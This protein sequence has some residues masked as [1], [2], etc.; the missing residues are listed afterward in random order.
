MSTTSPPALNRS[1]SAPPEEDREALTAEE[2]SIT[3]LKDAVAQTLETK[4]ILG[5]IRAQLRA[6]V[7]TA[8]DTQER[9]SG[10]HLENNKLNQLSQTE[11]GRATIA[12]VHDFLE[13]MDLHSTKSVFLAEINIDNE[14]DIKIDASD[15]AATNHLEDSNLPLLMQMMKR[16][17]ITSSSSANVSNTTSS[18]PRHNSKQ[19]YTSSPKT[20]GESKT[21]T[22]T[23]STTSQESKRRSSPRNNTTTTTNNFTNKNSTAQSS[24]R[25]T[26]SSKLQD[27]YDDDDYEDDNEF[28]D[29][30]KGRDSED[31]AFEIADDGLVSQSGS[32]ND[33]SS[34]FLGNSRS[35]MNQGDRSTDS[36]NMSTSIVQDSMDVSIQGSLAMDSYDFVEMAEQTSKT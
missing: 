33:D 11:D 18:S 12:L 15:Y 35:R 8:I 32:F 5:T 22:H 19:N 17:P 25:S 34:D 9:A 24:P 31:D 16:T 29:V 20:K 3:Q 23:R 10:I 7:F 4:G 28:E 30:D 26:S 13:S 6:A 2:Q 27:S 1:S 36:L 14:K 21:N